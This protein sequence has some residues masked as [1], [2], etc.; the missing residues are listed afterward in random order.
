MQHDLL[1]LKASLYGRTQNHLSAMS[2]FRVNGGSLS[3]HRV[4]WKEAVVHAMPLEENSF[5]TKS[6]AATKNL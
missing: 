3:I 2:G 4:L 1:G 6:D 5:D